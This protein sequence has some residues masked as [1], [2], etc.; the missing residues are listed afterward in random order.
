MSD[1]TNQKPLPSF[2]GASDDIYADL[3]VFHNACRLNPEVV[4][5]DYLYALHEFEPVFRAGYK[6][7]EP[8]NSWLRIPIQFQDIDSAT[9]QKLLDSASESETQTASSPSLASGFF[10]PWFQAECHAQAVQNDAY[11]ALDALSAA[12]RDK[13]IDDRALEAARALFKGGWIDESG[14]NADLEHIATVLRPF[15]A[16]PISNP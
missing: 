15:F 6:D 14:L 12:A 1:Q 16:K 4:A 2:P 13:A 3:A 10:D 11:A 9:A 7:L 8:G 5:V